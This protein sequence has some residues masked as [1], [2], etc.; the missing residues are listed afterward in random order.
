M[1]T[2]R[3]NSI[4][5]RYT[6][7]LTEGSYGSKITARLDL[8]E[9]GTFSAYCSDCNVDYQHTYYDWDCR[10]SATGKYTYN[11]LDHTLVLSP[12]VW[13]PYND[14]GYVSPVH[15]PI[16]TNSIE[17]FIW[18]FGIDYTGTNTIALPKKELL[19]IKKL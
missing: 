13:T 7:I 3:G 19:F 6:N 4:T 12:D 17:P 8:F 15:Y 1:H 18:H 2:N 14:K 9:N 16:I 5:I 11:K 10:I